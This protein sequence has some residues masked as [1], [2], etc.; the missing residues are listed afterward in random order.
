[1]FDWIWKGI[2]AITGLV[3][4]VFGV[5]A[6]RTKQRMEQ[7]EYGRKVAIDRMV[8]ECIMQLKANLDRIKKG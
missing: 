8:Y 3:A 4:L 2:T 5:N 1:M 6:A 7:E